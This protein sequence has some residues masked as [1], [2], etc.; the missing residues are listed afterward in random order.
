MGEGKSNQKRPEGMQWL[1][2]LVIQGPNH[3]QHK[4]FEGG[5][6]FEVCEKFQLLH[7]S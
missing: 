1:I 6:S 4:L 7:L 2:F 5:F 3:I